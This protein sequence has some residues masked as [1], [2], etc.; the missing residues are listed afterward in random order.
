MAPDEVGYL[1]FRA[2]SYYGEGAA[3]Q[4]IQLHLDQFFNPDLALTPSNCDDHLTDNDVRDF[5]PNYWLTAESLMQTELEDYMWLDLG[6]IVEVVGFKMKN[7][8]NSVW[9]DFSTK[10]IQ[11][12]MLPWH[13]TNRSRDTKMI[14]QAELPDSRDQV[15]EQ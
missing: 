13:K 4:Y 6:C 3:L 11:I 10:E 2:T 5:E 9:N 14:L 1:V 15:K 7:T 8:H 12:H